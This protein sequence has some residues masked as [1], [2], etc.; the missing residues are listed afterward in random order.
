MH[1][2]LGRRLGIG[3]GSVAGA[4]RDAEEMGERG[5]ADAPQTSL[6][7]AAGERSGA[8]RRLRKAPSVSQDQLPLE[9]A[10]VEAGVVGD[11]QLVARVGEEAAKDAADR[12]RAAELLLAQT[13][14]AGDRLRQ[15]HS[16]VHERLEGVDGL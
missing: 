13:G 5:E 16:W 4:G 12:G 2:H 15:R 11:Q 7:Q 3:E 1:E 10:L 14:Q 9:E 6:E 8:E